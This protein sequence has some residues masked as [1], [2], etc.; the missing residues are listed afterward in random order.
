MRHPFAIVFL[1]A[2]SS[3]QAAGGAPPAPATG[4]YALDAAACK[5]GDIFLTLTTSRL[6]LP[7]LSCLGL[8][9]DQISKT[10]DKAVWAVQA[11]K[12]V[13]EGSEKA[14]PKRFLLETG[15]RTL[16]IDWLDGTKSALLTRCGK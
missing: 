3:A 15:G 10:G 11:P 2:V 8:A 6:D 14:T 12:C 7:V 16:R 9:F 4:R 5:A 1:F 13:G